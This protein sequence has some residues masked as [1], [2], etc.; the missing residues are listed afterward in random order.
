MKF[1]LGLLL[2]VGVAGCALQGSA[3]DAPDLAQSEDSHAQ[4]IATEISKENTATKQSEE[5]DAEEIATDTPPGETGLEKNDGDSQATAT[6][7][8]PRSTAAEK[9]QESHA[10]RVAADLTS[11]ITT[12]DKIATADNPQDSSTTGKSTLRYVERAV[13]AAP[14]ESATD[15]PVAV[16]EKLG[17][18]LERNEQGEVTGVDLSRSLITDAGLEHLRSLAH[19][20]QLNLE[21][22][23][24]T[25]DGLVL[26]KGLTNLRELSITDTQISAA[27][28]AELQA[29]LPNCMTHR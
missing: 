2:V 6:E 29:A 20:Q 14:P 9:T 28:F 10:Q 27:G 16:L 12:T 24:I 5:E 18:K 7:S 4:L 17:A 23:R 25:D 21:G 8:L 3:V 15:I 19:L 13:T 26:L 11:E 22:T 1:F